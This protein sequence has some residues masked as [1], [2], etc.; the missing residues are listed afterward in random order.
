MTYVIFLFASPRLAKA[1]RLDELSST[2]QLSAFDEVNLLLE[3]LFL[4][5]ESRHSTST[6][7]NLE[8]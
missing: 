1:T 5:K 4:V 6:I 8:T 7:R 3:N 2:V